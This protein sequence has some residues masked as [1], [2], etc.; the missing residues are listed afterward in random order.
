MAAQPNFEEGQSTYRP[1]RF[2]GQNYGWWKTAMHDFIMAEDSELRDVICDGPFV[3][4]KTIREPTMSV[5]KTRKE[6]NDADRKAI[7]KNVRDKNILVCGIGPDE[8]NRISACQSAKEIWEAL[9]IAHEGNTQVKQSKIDMLKTEYELFRMKDDESIQD[10]HTHFTSI[11]NKLHSL[12][13][14]IPRNKL[15][16]RILS[17][18]PGSWE[19][20]A[21]VIT[22]AKD[23]QKLTIDELIGN[24]KTYEMKKKKKYNERRE[25]KRENNSK[26]RYSKKGQSSKPRGYDLCHKCGKLGHFIKDY[27]LLKQDQYKHNTDK[28]AK[29]NLVPDKQFKRKDVADNTVKQALAAW[30]DSSNESGEDDEQ[31]DNSMMA[32]ESEAAKYD[33]IFALMAKSD[34]D[35]DDDD[36]IASIEHERDDLLVVVVDLKETIEELKREGR[37]EITQKGK[38]VASEAHIKIENEL[39]TVKSSVCAELERNRQLQEDLGRVKSDL[40]KSPKWTWSSDA[41]AAMYTSN[42]GNKQGVGFQIEKTPYNPHSKYVIVP[43]NWLCTHYGNTGHFKENCKARIQSQQKNK[44]FVEKGAV[45]GS[46]QKWSVSFGNGKKGYIL[47]VGRIEKSLAHSIKNVYYVN[48]LKYSLL[49]VFQICDKGNKVE[50]VSKICTITILVTCEVVLVAKRY[51]NIYVSNFESLQNRDLSCLNIVDDDAE[52]WHRRL[53]HASFTLLNKLVKK[54]LVR[55][56]A[57]SSF[58]DH[59]VCDACVKG[60]QVRSSF[61]P[62]NEVSTSRPL[63]LLHMDLCVPMR[64][65]SRGGKKYIF[66]IV[67][68]YSRFTW[69]MFLRTKDETFQVFDAFVKMIQMKM[70]HNVVCIR[71]DHGTEFDNAKFDKFCAENALRKFDAKSDEGIFPGYSSQSKAYK[72]YNKR[73]QYV[74]ESI[75]VI[76]DESYHPC[77]KDS[78]DKIDQDGEQSVVPGEVIDMENGKADMMSQVKESNDEGIVVYPTDVEEPGSSIT[79][80]AAENRVVDAIRGTPYAELRSGT[81]DNQGSRS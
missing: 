14:I 13:E 32:V 37:H 4:M 47:G 61:K 51:K 68:D 81:H 39:Q 62:K 21:N 64:V 23:L 58:K 54:D 69:T 22:E 19:S 73:T 70:S 67:D 5:P 74:G 71:S 29:R 16:R 55:G 27:P 57:K 30:G 42:G 72:V 8:Y 79:T 26:L 65:P 18:L 6:Y 36:K 80:T 56:L 40:K 3:P 35:E 34:D 38:G 53:G 10:M 24:L 2:N 78:H 49:S 59:K 52:L 12:G 20:K 66:V 43:D 46:S 17:V 9:Q 28:A 15:L 11:I 76:F 1:P 48:G 50:F 45:K 77:G 75:H 44:V 33:S 60:K 31:G 25:P 63:Y 7:E 41:I